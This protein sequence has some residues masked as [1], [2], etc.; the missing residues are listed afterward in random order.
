MTDP[1]GVPP[2]M[3]GTL[4]AERRE[5][6]DGEQF[7]RIWSVKSV[8]KSGKCT[9]LRA[10]EAASTEQETL[11]GF[12]DKVRAGEYDDWRVLHTSGV[13]GAIT[14]AIETRLAKS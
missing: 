10:T 5:T 11:A 13:D 1:E 9:M 3:P 12:V 8:T 6:K 14:K 7:W 2:V 4:L